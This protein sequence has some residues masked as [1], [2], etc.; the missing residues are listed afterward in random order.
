MIKVTHDFKTKDAS[1][2]V[3]HYFCRCV[4]LEANEA[5]FKSSEEATQDLSVST[6]IETTSEAEDKA[7][8]RLIVQT[9]HPKQSKAYDFKVDMFGIFSFPEQVDKEHRQ[10]ILYTNGGSILYSAAR[11]LLFTLSQKLPFEDVILPTITF[12]PAKEGPE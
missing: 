8:V 6:T 11:E 12:V 2:D 5:G 3:V 1:I 9:T 4:Y 7:C 10:A